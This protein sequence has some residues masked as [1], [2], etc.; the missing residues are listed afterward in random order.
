MP[1]T[2]GTPGG[3]APALNA[4]DIKGG[5]IGMDG[6]IG[7]G[8]GGG[9]PAEEEG[10][11]GGGGGGGGA[12]TAAAVVADFVGDPA[13]RGKVW[14]MVSS[15]WIRDSRKTCRLRDSSSR[16]VTVNRNEAISASKRDLYNKHK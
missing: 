2:G 5:G 4:E 12:A 1:G 10:G 14:V 6:A 8:G 7:G 15:S 9:G 16:C 11:G 13:G 3:R